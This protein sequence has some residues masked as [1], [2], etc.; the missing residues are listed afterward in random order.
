MTYELRKKI[1]IY[2]LW[3]YQEKQNNNKRCLIEKFNDFYIVSMECDEK[4]RKNCVPVDIISKPVEH[5]MIR[6]NCYFETQKHWAYRSIYKDVNKIKDS[7]AWQCHN[8]PNY[9]S[10]EDE[11]ER[12]LEDFSCIPRIAYY[13]DT[14]NLVNFDVNLKHKVDLHLVA[15][16]SFEATAPTDSCVDSENTKKKKK[17]NA[18]S[19]VIIF[20]F[21]SRIKSLSRY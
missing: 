1:S 5:Q 18:V 15:H 19:Y 6:I 11:Y 13:F 3:K 21:S 4:E 20:F 12:Y 2:H 10:R 8:Y 7:C 14:Q 17:M 16:C 9:Y